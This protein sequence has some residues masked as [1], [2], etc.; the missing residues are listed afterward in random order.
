MVKIKNILKIYLIF[1]ICSLVSLAEEENIILK[2][3]KNNIKFGLT[4][5]L[6][7]IIYDY[8]SLSGDYDFINQ[9]DDYFDY[10]DENMKKS[11][12]E[13]VGKGIGQKDM[14]Y[15]RMDFSL[16]ADISEKTKVSSLIAMRVLNKDSGSQSDF[17][18]TVLSSNIEHKFD[19]TYKMK[20]GRVVEKYSESK[21][22]GR[23]AMGGKDSHVFGRTPFINDSL[24]INMKKG[25][26]DLNS[27]IKYNYNPFNF[28]GTYLISKYE[29]EIDEKQKIKIFGVYSLN[30][31]MGSEY[32][33]YVPMPEEKRISEN[34]NH[35]LEAEIAYNLDVNKFIAYVNAGC[36]I[37]YLGAAPHFS[38]PSD[39]TKLNEPIIY[40]KSD[41]IS[42][43]F[44][45]AGGIKINPSKYWKVL[46]KVDDISIELE[47]LGLGMD[48]LIAYNT[49]VHINYQIVKD[50]YL[51]YGLYINSV[52]YKDITNF[53]NTDGKLSAATDE[54]LNFLNYIR[55]TAP[56]KF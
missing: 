43:T 52:D 12:S 48:D 53:K 54:L 27:G 44:I 50:V 13:L 23:V 37:N 31:Q 32:E 49:Y 34:Y 45:L 46:N 17:S 28:A 3:I 14:H 6:D 10:K 29:T 25:K 16:D 21:M 18:Y 42:D 38:G 35:G 2:E 11:A 4:V 36:L 9:D 1:C 7:S 30:R 24:Q 40:E 51:Q 33:T 5:T 20:F 8:P 56:F 47:I 19:D 26:I 55:V 41:S 39:I 22:F 15:I